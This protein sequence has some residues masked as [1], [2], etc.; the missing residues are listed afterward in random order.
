MVT[1]AETVA[2]NRAEI[3]AA[4]TEMVVA[5]AKKMRA[6]LGLDARAGAHKVNVNRPDVTGNIGDGSAMMSTRIVNRQIAAHTGSP[7][8]SLDGAFPT[9]G[10][11]LKAVSPRSLQA[12]GLPPSIRADYSSQEPSAGGFLVPET[13]R[14]ELMMVALDNSIVRGRATVIPMSSSR[15]AIPALDVT[16][17]STSTFGGVV[18]TWTEEGAALAESEAKFGRIVL[19]ASKLTCRCDVPNELL[20]DAAPALDSVLQRIFG[21]SVGFEEDGAFLTGSGVGQPLGVLNADALISVAKETSQAA[22]TIVWE[23]LTKM[24][25]RLLASSRRQAIWICNDTTIPQL[26][27]MSIAIG[28]AGSAVPVM[29]PADGRFTILGLPVF[30]TSLT[31]VLGT[32]GDIILADLSYYLIGDRSELRIESSIHAQFT[33]DQTVYR[34]IE[35]VDGRSWLTS[36][37]TPRHGDSRSAFVALATRA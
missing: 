23:N 6:E 14:S 2:A 34:A 19:Q 27:S 5:T 25:A 3:E 29:T 30:F 13:F 32:V 9:F 11:Y 28:T 1:A 15:L 8:R 7:G 35:R 17:E 12:N 26:L 24:Y 16:S 36:A 33:T 22:N 4:A 37:I 10:D 31:P 18:G 21:A 20:M